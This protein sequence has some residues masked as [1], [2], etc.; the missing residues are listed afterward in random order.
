MSINWRDFF[1]AQELEK[2]INHIKQI[3][4]EENEDSQ[5]EGE[6]EDEGSKGDAGGSDS[7]PSEDNIDQEEFIEIMQTV[8]K[9]DE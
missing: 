2:A 9:K 5:S 8:F 7:D 6:D 3:P 4:E 1:E